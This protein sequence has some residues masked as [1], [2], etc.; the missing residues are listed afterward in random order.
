MVIVYLI[1]SVL[2][3]VKQGCLLSPLLFSLYIN[4]LHECF[5]GGFNVAG[6][7]VKVLLDAEDLIILAE[8]EVELQAMINYL[9]NYC[10]NWALNINLNKSKVVVFRQHLRISAS[11]ES[12]NIS[13][14]RSR[15]FT[16]QEIEHTIQKLNDGNGGS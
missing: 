16:F 10:N 3:G 2:Q 7:L 15:R 5:P 4:D 13:L 12:A 1:L 14:A 6:T 8:S 11:L 9:Y